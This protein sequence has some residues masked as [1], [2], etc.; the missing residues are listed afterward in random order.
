MADD[1]REQRIADSP[2]S[3]TTQRKILKV[4]GSKK[5]FKF[6]EPDH[7]SRVSRK[8]LKRNITQMRE[9]TVSG[10]SI[11]LKDYDSLNKQTVTFRIPERL[12]MYIE[13]CSS[14]IF[15]KDQLASNRHSIW[16]SK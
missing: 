16:L 14:K 10:R 8:Y 13:Q 4:V 11:S 12:Q 2:V 3:E 9:L 1:Y 5:S 15:S 7:G 6:V